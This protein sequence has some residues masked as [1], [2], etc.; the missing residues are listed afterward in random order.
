MGD[1]MHHFIQAVLGCMW[2]GFLG[3]FIMFYYQYNFV[4][5]KKSEIEDDKSFKV[6]Y[7]EMAK[8]SRKIAIFFCFFAVVTGCLLYEIEHQFLECLCKGGVL[9]LIVIPLMN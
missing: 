6:V 9:A 1:S 5:Y 4:Y 8:M 2:I 3:L 7:R